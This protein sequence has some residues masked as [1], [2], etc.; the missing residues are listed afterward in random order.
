MSKNMI[1]AAG[2]G[3][4]VGVG[5]TLGIGLPSGLLVTGTAAEEMAQN[6]AV[7]SLVPLCVAKFR[8]TPDAKSLLAQIKGMNPWSRANFVKDKG[9]GAIAGA[10]IPADEV[11]DA[12]ADQLAA[13]NP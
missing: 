9:W 2:I 3:L 12:C 11:A 13:L 10:D 7:D 1:V 8:K 6:A 5:A 4:A